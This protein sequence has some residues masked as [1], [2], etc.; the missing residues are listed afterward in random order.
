MSYD[1]ALITGAQIVDHT[2]VQD[3]ANLATDA[4]LVLNTFA[5][6][7]HRTIYRML[8]GMGVDPTLLANESRLNEAVA[9][10]A[11][12]RLSLAGYLPGTDHAAFFGKRDEVL[13]GVNGKGGFRPDY[14]SADEPRQA[15]EAIP[16][17]GH[18]DGGMVFSGDMPGTTSGYFSDDYPEAV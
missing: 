13:F 10:E 7:A 17:V 1:S 6:N 2:G 14:A 8:E 18:A 5:L 16:S 9:W 4:E 15:H 3:L 11:V 12:G